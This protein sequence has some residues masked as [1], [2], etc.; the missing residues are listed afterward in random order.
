MRLSGWII[1]QEWGFAVLVTS[2]KVVMLVEA[3]MVAAVVAVAV[4]V[5]LTSLETESAVLLRGFRAEM[6]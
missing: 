2:R 4:V 5:V 6:K 3:V 1:F